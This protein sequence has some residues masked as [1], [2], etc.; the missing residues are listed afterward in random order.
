MT[1]GNEKSLNTYFQAEGRLKEVRRL[2]EGK[3]RE[4]V[5]TAAG[6]DK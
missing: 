5:L 6:S 3:E 1:K 4:R 2:D